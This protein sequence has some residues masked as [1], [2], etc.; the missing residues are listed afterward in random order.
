MKINYHIHTKWSKDVQRNNNGGT[1]KEFAEAAAKAGIAEICITDHLVV[2]YPDTVPLHWNS[3]GE[4]NIY[5]YFEDTDSVATACPEV[6]ARK[7]VEVDWLPEKADEIRRVLKKYPFD[8]VIGSVHTLNGTYVE[9]NRDDINKFWGKLSSGHVYQRYEEYY[10][11]VQEMAGSGICDV[12]AHLDLIK[13]DGYI[14]ERN[15]IPLV[16]ETLDIIS[17]NNLCVEVNTAGMRKPA[18]E[19]HPSFEILKVCKKK[20]IPVTIG[21][22]AHEVRQIDF[23]L[24]EGMEMIKNAGYAELAVFEKRKRSFVRI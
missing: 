13:R 2:G 24:D 16:E 19:I 7:G 22:D 15:A 18:K 17:E 12:V 1:A 8:C 23:Y 5:K 6:I 20:E 11:A 9:H 3:I 4:K 14:P 10:S 21:T